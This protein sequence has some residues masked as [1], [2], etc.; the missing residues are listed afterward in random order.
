[1]KR[2]VYKCPK[3]GSESLWWDASAV[4]NRE[5]QAHELS[6]TFRRVYCQEC[7]A[8][9]SEP[10]VEV[11]DQIEAEVARHAAAQNVDQ[12]FDQIADEIRHSGIVKVCKS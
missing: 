6:S 7:G 12:F 2:V 10:T 8:S 3:C 4:W 9:T 1:M 11:L 5:T